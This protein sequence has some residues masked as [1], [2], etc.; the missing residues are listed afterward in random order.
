M[1]VIR[2]Y[3][4]VAK[5]RIFKT[6][7]PPVFHVDISAINLDSPSDPFIHFEGGL[8]R[9]PRRSIPGAYISGG[10]AD[11]PADVTTLW[12][13]LW[14]LLGTKS[15]DDAGVTD[16]DDESIG[17]TD[18]NGDVTFTLASN[19]VVYGS[20]KI[21]DS[22]AA[23]V[24]RDNGFGIFEAGTPETLEPHST[25]AGE[26]TLDYT[27]DFPNV[28]AGTLEIDVAAALVAHDVD[29]GDGTGTI[30]QDNASGI[31]GT[32]YYDTGEISL[33]GLIAS[34]QYDHDYTYV[35]ASPVL[36]GTIDYI[37]GLVTLTGLGVSE[38][39]TS[40]YSHGNYV[41]TIDSQ[42]DNILPSASFNAGK[43]LY[44]HDFNGCG[45]N[46]FDISIDNELADI[47]IDIQ[48]GEDAK[49]TIL[50]EDKLK[51]AEEAPIPFHQ[52]AFTYGDFGGSL[53][54]RSCEVDAISLSVANNA[55]AEG[56]LGLN[57]RFPCRMYAGDF[58]AT[59]E[60]TLKFETLEAKEDFWGDTNGP[61]IT[62]QEK[63][64]QLTLNAGVYGNIVLDIPKG[65]I[66]TVPHTPS[67]RARL[68]QTLTIMLRKDPST[69]KIL[70]AICTVPANWG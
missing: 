38:A 68:E 67:G 60:L 30:V 10:S 35:A 31:S 4:G 46:S 69:L 39:H 17:S 44:Q 15:T 28:I 27:L 47:S 57:D 62:P 45:F 14:L 11:F 48:G 9:H 22:G 5:E 33:T 63:R 8:G 40:D 61:S 6:A 18:G 51:L 25:G 53:V 52:I 55:D 1:T 50:D 20:C 13:F 19:P 24:A 49:A 42:E 36:H 16:V 3:L 29:N 56:G 64:A 21:Q 66:I 2:R 41:H 32:I 58:T 23:F 70:T 54:D 37:I 59:M 34:T 7:R 43:D 26:T 65:L 12:Y